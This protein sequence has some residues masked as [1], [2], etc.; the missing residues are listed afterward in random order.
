MDFLKR[1]IPPLLAGDVVLDT[2]DCFQEYSPRL[3][4]MRR[5]SLLSAE[6]TLDE[7]E[8]S[9]LCH[10]SCDKHQQ[11]RGKVQLCYS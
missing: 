4:K 11:Q 2:T 1:M 7:E 6:K 5:L 10:G 3:V 8:G 9:S